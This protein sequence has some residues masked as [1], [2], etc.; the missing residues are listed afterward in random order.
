MPICVKNGETP[1]KANG[2]VIMIDGGFCKAYQKNTGIAGNTLIYNSHG[3]R[4][5]AH[6]RFESREKACIENKDIVSDSNIIETYKNRICVKDSDNG[7]IIQSTVKQLRKLL[8]MYI[9]QSHYFTYK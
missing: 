7:K 8:S 5:K 4:M 1:L 3:L 2:K 9:E 6:G